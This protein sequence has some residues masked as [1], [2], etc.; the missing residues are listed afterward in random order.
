MLQGYEIS[1]ND[2]GTHGLCVRQ[3]SDNQYC[4]ADAQAVRPYIRQLTD[5]QCCFTDAQTVRPYVF[6]LY[7]PLRL[8]LFFCIGQLT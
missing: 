7:D 1:V 4:F 8:T 6:G 5:S 3:L 2:V